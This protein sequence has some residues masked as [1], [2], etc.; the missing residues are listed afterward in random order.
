MQSA[1]FHFVRV[2][3]AR[4]VG[5]VV[6][7]HREQFLVGHLAIGLLQLVRRDPHRRYPSVHT[8]LPRMARFATCPARAAA[9]PISTGAVGV[10][11]DRTQ[12][13]KFFMWSSPPSRGD[14]S[15]AVTGGIVKPSAYRGISL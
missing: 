15:C 13:R 4:N 8:P 11:R 7:V 10:C 1:P 5:K 14:F 3:L 6:C 12:S 9:T 2:A